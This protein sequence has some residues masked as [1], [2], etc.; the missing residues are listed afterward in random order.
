MNLKYISLILIFCIG[1]VRVHAQGYLDFVENKG[2]WESFIQF[3]SELSA[4]AFALTK[5]GYR[6]LQHN[7][8]DYAAI[9]DSK[10]AYSAHGKPA[11]IS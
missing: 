8:D 11:I 10:H 3:K 4:S 1:I 9:A 2:Q 7:V 5:N 6:V